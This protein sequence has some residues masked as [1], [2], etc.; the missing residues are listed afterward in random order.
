MSTELSPLQITLDGKSLQVVRGSNDDFWLE[1]SKG[2]WEPD[3]LS[4]F[5]RFI[6]KQHSYIDIGA[7][8]GP[9][10]MVGCQLARCAYVIEPDPVAYK[11]L[12][13]NLRLNGAQTSNVRVF[14]LCITP[15]AGQY[16]FGSRAEGGDS[17]SSLLFAGSKTTWT[18]EGIPFADFVSQNGIADCNFIKMDIEGGEYSV[19]PTMLDFLRQYRPTLHLSV[20]PICLGDLEAKSMPGRLRRSWFRLAQTTQLLH[21]LRFYRHRY[22]CLGKYPKTLLTTPRSYVHHFLASLNCRPVT[23]LLACRQAIAGQTITL[24]LTDQKW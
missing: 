23:W 6:D 9:T 16:S 12:A 14:S 1:C 13:E 8:I 22:D 21:H 24:L 20:H 19:I 7:W 11:E 2:Q 5:K 15:T 18:V 4:A 10:V 3:T 17:R